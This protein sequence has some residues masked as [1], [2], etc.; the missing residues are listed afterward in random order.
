MSEVKRLDSLATEMLLKED[1]YQNTLTHQKAEQRSS[2]I[3]QMLGLTSS[4]DP[5]DT[6]AGDLGDLCSRAI[7]L[8]S[9]LLVSPLE[10]CIHFFQQGTTFDEPSM[11]V[12]DPFGNAVPTSRCIGRL[13]RL[14][15][16][17]AIWQYCDQP[18]NQTRD[19]A[20]ALTVNRKFL[21][22]H[23]GDSKVHLSLVSK[24]V[25]LLV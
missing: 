8:Y 13:V 7:K 5:H 17:P 22:T 14:C 15:L 18:L 6:I 4:T 1:R 16:F 11:K 21:R 2:W 20:D 10:Y 19:V 9:K 12:E 23:M 25:V 3:S 24:A